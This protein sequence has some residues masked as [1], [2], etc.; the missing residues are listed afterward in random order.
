MHKVYLS[1]SASRSWSMDNPVGDPFGGAAYGEKND[2]VTAAIGGA[3]I[4]GGM[5]LLGASEQADATQAAANTSAEASRYSADIQK[6]IYDQTRTDQKPWRDAGANALAQLA[7]LT[8][9]NGEL[10]RS[11]SMADYK[12]DP[13]YKF[14]MDEGAKALERSAAARGGLMSGRAAKDMQRF[15]QGL[16][17]EEYQNAYN[18]FQSNQNN[19]FNRLASMAGV[20]QTA[21]NALTSAGQ[22]YATN[23]GNAAMTAGGNAATAQLVGGMGRASAYQGMGNALGKVNWGG[24]FGGGGGG[25]YNPANDGVGGL[26]ASYI[27]GG[28]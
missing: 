19:K 5:G 6:Q 26:S 28:F 4:S 17:S 2:P 10:L 9:S 18:R 1:R 25:Y 12:E 14:R 20:G 16:A 11:F 22:N 24:L 21:N 13:G 23:V 15:S 3:V 7:G 27:Q 8:G